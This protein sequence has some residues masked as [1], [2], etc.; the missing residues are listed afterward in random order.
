MTLLE[1]TEP[2]F[3]YV[4]RLN[5]LARKSGAQPTGETTFISKSGGIRGA[6][7]EYTLVRNDLKAIFEDMAQKSEKDFRLS[8][9]YKKVEL[10]LLFFVDSIISEGTL[11]FALE[12]N[13]NRMAFDRNELAG[14]EKFFDLL[15]EDSKDQSDE[16]SE[17]LAVYYT[18]VGL[19][20]TGFYFK[21]PEFLRKTMLSI[22]PRIRRWVEADEAAKICADAYEATDTRELTEPP[23][24]KVLAVSLIFLCLTAAALVSYVWLYHQSAKELNDSLDRITQNQIESKK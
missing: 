7:L 20:F 21:Q 12:W 23:S 17:R 6:N 3:Q 19:G 8:S 4:C 11:K 9:Q 24:R 13:K 18:C 16:A 10:P 5:R 22:A 14:D 15:E 1:L 2:L